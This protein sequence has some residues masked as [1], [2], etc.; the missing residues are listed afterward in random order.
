MVVK[1][2][3]VG[4]AVRIGKD[5]N[6]HNQNPSTFMTSN[7]WCQPQIRGVPIGMIMNT[8]SGVPRSLNQPFLLSKCLFI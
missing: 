8:N 7:I 3:F 4:S 2:S 6:T 5:L 1:I